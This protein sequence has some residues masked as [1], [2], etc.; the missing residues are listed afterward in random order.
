MRS[1]FIVL[2]AMHPLFATAQVEDQ[3]PSPNDWNFLN[4][5]L[6]LHETSTGESIKVLIRNTDDSLES[7]AKR[8][9]REWSSRY[10]D[11]RNLRMLLVLGPSESHLQVGYGL[12]L[13]YTRYDFQ[14]EWDSCIDSHFQ[15]SLTCFFFSFFKASESPALDLLK[16]KT[17]DPKNDEPMKIPSFL[18]FLF[19]SIGLFLFGLVLSFLFKLDLYFFEGEKK[20]FHPLLVFFKLKGSRSQEALKEGVHGSWS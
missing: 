7:F 6:K 10:L 3:R 17:S 20:K 15:Q 11:Q 4:Q 2:M 16:K 13:L 19:F 5:A 1:L 12:E 14:E 9:Y 8:Y 18:S